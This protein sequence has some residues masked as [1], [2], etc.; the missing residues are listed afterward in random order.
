MTSVLPYLMGGSSALSV[1]TLGLLFTGDLWA[2]ALTATA[3]LLLAAL[4]IPEL[5]RQ[6]DSEQTL[7]N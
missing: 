5:V 3:A 4:A 7:A 2:M 6:E 1:L